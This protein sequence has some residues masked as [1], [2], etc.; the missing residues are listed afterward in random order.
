MAERKIE[1]LNPVGEVEVKARK[2]APRPQSLQGLTLGVLDNSKHNADH[3]LLRAGQR[4]K[5]KLGLKEIIVR[6]KSNPSLPAPQEIKAELSSCNLL[7]T[8][9]GD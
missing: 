5:E 4:L 6:R 3:F 7:I 8:A 1:V 2:L 9:F